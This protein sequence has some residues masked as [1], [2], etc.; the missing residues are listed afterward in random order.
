MINLRTRESK[1]LFCKSEK[2]AINAIYSLAFAVAAFFLIDVFAGTEKTSKMQVYE[3]YFNAEY[4][5]HIGK[6]T[7]YHPEKYYIDVV[8]GNT[9]REIKLSESEYNSINTTDIINVLYVEGFITAWK[10][11]CELK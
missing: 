11:N 5:T 4:T 9:L 8:D 3:K 7:Y 10:H 2:I 6:S 1:P